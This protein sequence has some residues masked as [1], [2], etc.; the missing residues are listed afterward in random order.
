MVNIA[1]IG[2]GDRGSVLMEILHKRDDLSI[3]GICDIDSESPGMELA[4]KMGIPAYERLEDVLKNPKLDLVIETTGKT[5][6]REQVQD[7]KLDHA[8]LI[9]VKSPFYI[10]YVKPGE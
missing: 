3:L 5:S 1:I 6:V 7:I 4:R 2:G 8:F 10:K 9:G